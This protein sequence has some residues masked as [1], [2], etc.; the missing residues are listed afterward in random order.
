M[1]NLEVNINDYKQIQRKA[2]KDDLVLITNAT[3][4]T[5]FDKN[6]IGKI[7][8]VTGDEKPEYLDMVQNHVIVGNNL[9]YDFQYIVLEKI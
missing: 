1:I 3:D 5:A 4:S 6:H 7:Y 2:Y 8:K 9:L